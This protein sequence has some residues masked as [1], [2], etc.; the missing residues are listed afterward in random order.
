MGIFGAI[1]V[2]IGSRW[3]SYDRPP[4]ALLG[5]ATLTSDIDSG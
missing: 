3:I 4:C 1:L 5:L 2:V